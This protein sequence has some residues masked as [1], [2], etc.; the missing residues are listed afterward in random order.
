MIDRILNRF[1]PQRKQLQSEVENLKEELRGI[2][3]LVGRIAADICVHD[4]LRS[5]EFKVYSQFGEDGIL[6]FLVK[7]LPISNKIFIEFG[8]EHYSEANT[9]FLLIN[10]NWKGLIIDGSKEHMDFVRNQDISWRYDLTAVAKFITKENINSI[11]TENGFEGKIGILSIDIDG[12]DYWVWENINTV[13]ADIV[14]AEYNSVYGSKLAVSVPYQADFYR[15]DHH[16]S[17]LYWGCSL[18][19]LNFLAEKKGYALV[20]CNNNGNNCFFVKKSLLNGKVKAVSVEDAYV[21]SK[22]RESRDEQGNLT[23]ITG[24]QRLQIIKDLTVVEVEL[25]QKKKISELL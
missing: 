19:A 7:N 23:F 9:R 3:N 6:Q 24:S 15:T 21:E 12:N 13:D 25:N 16:T 18:K 14:V 17:N 11:F 8:V 1:S 22:F 20:G 10:D 5:S 4:D 2:K